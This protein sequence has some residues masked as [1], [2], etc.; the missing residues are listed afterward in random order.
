MT[1][2]VKGEAQSDERFSQIRVYI[3]I[4]EMVN[5]CVHTELHLAVASSIKFSNSV[6]CTYAYTVL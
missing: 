1:D 4:R 2:D 3:Y 5:K 6:A